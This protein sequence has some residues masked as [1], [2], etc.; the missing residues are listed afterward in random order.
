[1]ALYEFA[2][3]SFEKRAAV[4]SDQEAEYQRQATEYEER[5]KRVTDP[6]IRS[7]YLSLAKHCRE[8]KRVPRRETNCRGSKIANRKKRA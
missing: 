6:W 7:K 8:M 5:S 4:M 1:V 3:I 2:S